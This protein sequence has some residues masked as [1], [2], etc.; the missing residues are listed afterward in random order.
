MPVD[1][2]VIIAA[3]IVA[4]LLFTWSIKVLKASISTALSI[5]IIALILQLFLGIGFEE[6][7][8]KLVQ[9]SQ[10]VGQFFTQ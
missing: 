8:Q 4:W 5:A 9:F 1:L 3:I 2:I 10:T 6:V 7:W